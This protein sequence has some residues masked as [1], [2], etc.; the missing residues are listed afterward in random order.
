[1]V[2]VDDYD[3]GPVPEGHQ[4]DRHGHPDC[5][6]VDF[7]PMPGMLIDHDLHALQGK[8]ALISGIFE[9]VDEIETIWCV[10]EH[11]RNVEELEFHGLQG[12]L[13]LE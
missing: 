2:K 10:E 6:I 5:Q 3:I 9:R 11:G 4:L 13:L 1:M 8:Y 7:V 12:A